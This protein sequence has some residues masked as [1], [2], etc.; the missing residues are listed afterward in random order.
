MYRYLASNNQINGV[1][2]I[3]ILDLCRIFTET[4]LITKI[5]PT[6]ILVII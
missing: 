6:T 2:S 3:N 1:Y 4:K 5:F